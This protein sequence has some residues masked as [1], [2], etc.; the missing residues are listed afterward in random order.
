M[1]W[2]FGAVLAAIFVP[3]LGGQVKAADDKDAQAVLDKAI[4]A[5]GGE[6]KLSKIKAAT[7]KNKGKIT[8]KGDNTEF[9]STLTMQG[10]DRIR[11]TFEREFNGSKIEF[12][13]VLT[14]DKGWQKI[15]NKIKV[16]DE[17]A[18]IAQKRE[19][20]RQIVPITLLPLKGKGFKIA[21]AGEKKVGDKATVGLKVTGPAG[22]DF[23]LYFDK[24][25][26]LPILM[27]AKGVGSKGEEFTWETTFADYKEFAGIKKATKI[28]SKRDGEEFLEYQI[29]EFRVLDT[30]DPKTFEEPK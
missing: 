18:R 2:F 8:F 25:S 17:K 13:T 4:Q 26:G 1:K 21:A 19:M 27:A 15:G 10:I 9:T 16:M 11:A 3:D 14:K 22:A 6:E 12:V 30:V 5:L 7:W 28:V 29:T 23:T 24:A 20:Y